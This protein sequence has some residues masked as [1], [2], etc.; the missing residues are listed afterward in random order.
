LITFAQFSFVSVYGLFFTS[1]FFT[2]KRVI[3]LKDYA[4]LVI[5]FF[6]SNVCNNY[7]LKFNIPMPLLLIFRSGSLIANM[8]M[9]RMILKRRYTFWK[10][11]SVIM[12]TIGIIVCTL[13]SRVNVKESEESSAFWWSIGVILMTVSLLLTARM[14]IFQETLFRR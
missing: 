1:K 7:A 9:S 8:I 10:Y 2:I 12:I 5:I 6:V 3:K 4:I 11:F 14:G 13:M